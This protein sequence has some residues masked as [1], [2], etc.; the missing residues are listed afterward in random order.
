MARRN[1]KLYIILQNVDFWDITLYNVTKTKDIG[2]Y[3][4]Q[5]KKLGYISLLMI[6]CLTLHVPVKASVVPETIRIGLESVAKDVY[7]IQVNSEKDLVIGYFNG[8]RWY[9]EGEIDTNQIKISQP[10]DTY[11]KYD[12]IYYSFEDASKAL[13]AYDPSAVVA[14]IEPGSYGIYTTDEFYDTEQVAYNKKRIVVKDDQGDA[15]LV[16]EN[17]EVPLGFQGSYSKYNFPA[18]GV[19]SGRMYRGVVEIVNGQYKGLTAVNVVT[20]EDYLYG[21]VNNEMGGLNPQEALRTQAVAARSMATYQYKRFLSRGYNL[22]D[23]T[24]SQVY[25]GI[26]SEHVNTTAAVDDTKGEVAMYNGKVA[27]T[28]YSASSG[29]HT[30]N[31]KYVWGN[32]VGYLRGVADPFT[33]SKHD[34]ERTITL[35]EIEKCLQGDGIN[36]GRVQGVEITGW[37]PCGRVS[38][39]RI[40]G[41]SG[42]HLLTKEAPRTFFHD[43]KDGSLKSTMFKF[44]PYTTKSG[45]GTTKATNTEKVYILSS[46]GTQQVNVEDTYAKGNETISLDGK[47]SVYIQTKNGIVTLGDDS[48]TSSG[49]SFDPSGEK[50]IVYG[51]IT[52]YGKGFGHG[53]GMSQDGAINMAKQGYTYEDILKF[54]YPGVV[55]ER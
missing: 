23:T 49:G 33:T 46:E 51:D 6:G 3:G 2:G 39:L 4:L 26:T 15:V 32:E 34:W 41:S 7:E 55:I 53:V 10:E 31:S 18:T 36:I 12:Q 11:Y 38:G 8:D 29:G 19:G 37:T 43:S 9:E 14:Y 28:V 30:A 21:V 24:T 1:E 17:D 22:V 13:E 52:L 50:T 54:Y 47:D 40:L 27:E 45:S 35:Q 16:S 48:E 44:T 42:D 5:M 25:K 20:M